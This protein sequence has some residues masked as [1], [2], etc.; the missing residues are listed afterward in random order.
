MHIEL[1]LPPLS[2]EIKDYARYIQS[3]HTDDRYFV[4]AKNFAEKNNPDINAAGCLYYTDNTL[5]YLLRKEFGHLFTE[6]FKGQLLQFKN[7]QSGNIASYPPHTDIGKVL[8]LNYVL[9]TGGP[10][11]NTVFYETDNYVNSL[12]GMTC[13]YKNLTINDIL[14]TKQD[15]WYLLD[16]KNIH[17][18]ESIETCRTIICLGFTSISYTDFI[19]KYN[20]LVKQP[21]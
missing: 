3:M 6:N 16:V 19:L 4:K 12:E 13:P 21:V 8:N 5:T 1:I 15:H 2:T 11:V 9:D 20:N 7:L 10:N 18:V 17:S 14:Y